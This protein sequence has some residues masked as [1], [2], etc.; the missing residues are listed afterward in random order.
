MCCLP[1]CISPGESWTQKLGCQV[2]SGTLGDGISHR[3]D[4]QR[5]ETSRGFKGDALAKETDKAHMDKLPWIVKGQTVGSAVDFVGVTNETRKG[6]ER[7]HRSKHNAGEIPRGCPKTQ[8]KQVAGGGT[9]Y[10]GDFVDFEF[11]ELKE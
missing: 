1:S 9:F 5:E 3:C 2:P 7:E 6:K 4:S 11:L 10:L 8:S